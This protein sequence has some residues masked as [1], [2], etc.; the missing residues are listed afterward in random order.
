MIRMFVGADGTNRDLES[1]AVLEYSVRKF[2]SEP[3]EIVWMQ[4][5][6]AGPWSG[7]HTESGRTP[8]THFRWGVPAACGYEGK[9]IYVD[10][11]F[12]FLADIAELWHQPVPNVILLHSP[13]GKLKTSCMVFDCEKAE[14][15]IPSLKALKQMP[16]VNGTFTNYFREH[17]E[18]LTAYEGDWNC[19]DGGKYE[20]MQDPRLKALHYSRIEH[21]CHLPYAL[22]RLKAEGRKH[23]YN[24]ETSAHPRADVQAAFNALYAEACDA[25][26]PPERYRVEPFTAATRR[27]FKYRVPA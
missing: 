7:W 19:I 15:H 25:G 17:R 23:W 4:Q 18:L 1:Q 16:D 5:A 3:V 26:F 13:E 8:F 14:G 6:A 2:A 10:S 20:S 9:A 12:F 27:D 22:A 24:G 21:Q 11:D